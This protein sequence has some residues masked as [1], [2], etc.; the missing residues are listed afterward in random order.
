MW[1]DLGHIAGGAAEAAGVEQD[2][3]W[4][5]TGAAAWGALGLWTGGLA[6][7]LGGPA[8]AAMG[9]RAGAAAGRA[10]G[11]R[12][13]RAFSETSSRVLGTYEEAVVA[14]PGVVP[15]DPARRTGRRYNFVL[16]MFTNSGIAVWGDQALR[17][18]YRKRL[19]PITRRGFEGYLIGA[20]GQ[21]LLRA[22]LSTRG[23][24]R[25]GT[26]PGAEAC[27]W[28]QDPLLGELGSGVFAV[29]WLERP[30]GA[31]ARY[32]PVGGELVL[33]AHA[34]PGLRRAHWLLSPGGP[35]RR[36][37]CFAVRDQ[38]TCVTYP[39]HR[40]LDAL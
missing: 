16:A 21:A 11:A 6:G 22:E 28:L 13:G 35:G 40:R 1:L 32:A 27:P 30:A 31:R 29:S 33:A 17:Y 3:F 34:I 19:T 26:G 23:D 36:W 7:W 18:G 9:A 10:F 15:S 38:P 39:E 8:G 2:R 37:G 12:Q 14:V 20:P 5:S 25:P 24:W 4:E